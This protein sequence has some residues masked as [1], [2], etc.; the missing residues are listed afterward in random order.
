MNFTPH[1]YKVLIA[2][3]S[4]KFKD[5][6]LPVLT[7]FGCETIQSATSCASARR[8]LLE[9]SFD[10][11][12][13]NAPLPD[14]FGTKMALDFSQNSGVAILLFVK[15]E[16]FEETTARVSP[17]GILTVLKPTAMSILSQSLTLVMATRERLRRMEQKTASIEEK[18][19]EIR[20][21]NRA[22]W[23]LIEHLHMT[24]PEAHRYIEKTAMD[25][26]KP[27]RDI[28]ESIIKTYP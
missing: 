14:E 10:L 16:H 24:E 6:I 3:S 8:K 25:S 18:M 17:Y 15:A 22:K 27:K 21:V 13:I 9:E 5:S 12:V 20:L 11:V 23:K 2:S 1:S 26:C 4:E 19:E 7:D 28:A